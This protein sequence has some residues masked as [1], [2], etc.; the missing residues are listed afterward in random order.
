[1]K[2]IKGNKVILVYTIIG[3][4]FGLCF[5]LGAYVVVGL[6]EKIPFM[7]IGKLHEANQLLYM[8]DSAPIFLGLFAMMGGFNQYKAYRNN[9]KLTETLSTIKEEQSEKANMLIELENESNVVNDLME[10]IKITNFTLNENEPILN[11]TMDK[12]NE[13]EMSLK[14]RVDEISSSLSIIQEILKVLVEQSKTDLEK[15]SIMKE[16]STEAVKYIERYEKLNIKSSLE[17]NES[18][19]V[20]E[21]LV[22]DANE[23]RNI[24]GIIDNISGQIDLLSLNASIESA[25]A[26]DAGKGFAVVADE[27]KKLSSKTQD[28]TD[29]IGDMINSLI[30]NIEDIYSKMDILVSSSDKIIEQNDSTKSVLENIDSKSKEVLESYKTSKNYIESLEDNVTIID[31]QIISVNIVSNKLTDKVYK[32]KEALVKNS[33]QLKNLNLLVK[34]KK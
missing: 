2:N 17:L 11:L 21:S 24:I 9:I 19:N 20:L 27:I 1:M 29:K 4:I 5:P 14:K 13:Q 16:S 10:G 3:V 26:G 31:N 23:A 25:R 28:A 18:K 32:G 22:K 33:E 8:I 6:L 34:D 30:G 7:L 12:I 15:V